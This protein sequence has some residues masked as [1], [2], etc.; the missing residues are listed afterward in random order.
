MYVYRVIAPSLPGEVTDRII[1]FVW[2]HKS[3]LCSCALVCRNWLPA[4]R[5]NLF[6]EVDV[7]I[8]SAVS[9]DSWANEVLRRRDMKPWLSFVRSLILSDPRPDHHPS[10]P[11]RR[12]APRDLQRR[13]GQRFLHEF[14]NQLPNLQHMTI[15]NLDWITLP[16]HWSTHMVLGSYAGVRKFGLRGCHFSSFNT[17]RRMLSA[18]PLLVHLSMREVGW[19]PNRV[20]VLKGPENGFPRPALECLIIHGQS[21][22]YSTLFEWLVNTPS[23][24]TLKELWYNLR[25]DWTDAAFRFLRQLSNTVTKFSL[26]LYTGGEHTKRRTCSTL[27]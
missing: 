27:R 6:Y 9:Y 25:G 20:P 19:P 23:Q 1:R 10:E 12:L 8:N 4:S 2:P 17:L 15:V 7:Y 24:H 26:P 5:V 3:T 13:R 14:A 21:A 18:L 16:P 22:T 11:P